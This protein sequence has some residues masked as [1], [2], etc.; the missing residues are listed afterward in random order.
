MASQGQEKLQAL[1]LSGKKGSLSAREQA[2]AWAMREVWPEDQP[3]H[4][5]YTFIAKRVTKVGGG[6]PTGEAVKA[7]LDKMDQDPEWFPGKAN[8]E[9]NGRP[10][11]LRG[12]KVAAIRNSAM[13]LKER[14]VEPT[15]ALMVGACPA[16]V[17]N[18]DNGRPVGK[19]RVYDVFRER[20]YDETPDKPWKHRARLSRK[21]L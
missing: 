7:F 5:M 8:Y 13:A 6:R 19:K 17:E 2:K 14:S 12:P 4:G 16:A 15:C 10:R 9:D 20:C 3:T 11:V 1:W 21:A 18:P